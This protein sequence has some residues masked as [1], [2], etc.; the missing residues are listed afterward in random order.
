M[1][2]N[3]LISSYEKQLPR[4]K[5]FEFWSIF[6]RFAAVVSVVAFFIGIYYKPNTIPEWI[7]S[8]FLCIL[9]LFLV[10]YA[11]SGAL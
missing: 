11:Y 3:A 1:K 6:G 5:P 2:K 8:I 4:Y 9:V 7:Y 10:A